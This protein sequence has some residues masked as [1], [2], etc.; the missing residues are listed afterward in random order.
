LAQA[1]SS[2]HLLSMDG[3]VWMEQPPPRARVPQP[4]RALAEVELLRARLREL[5]E[6]LAALEAGRAREAEAR[7]RRLQVLVTVVDRA[8]RFVP[9]PVQR[10]LWSAARRALVLV[11]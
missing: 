9:A 4:A 1:G 7:A 6:R 3:F 5:E 10:L 8:A 11:T 2:L